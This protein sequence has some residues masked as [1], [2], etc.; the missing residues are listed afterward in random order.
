MSLFKLLISYL[1]RAKIF[2][3]IYQALFP[4]PLAEVPELKKDAARVLSA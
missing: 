3:K 2:L 1:T 4:V